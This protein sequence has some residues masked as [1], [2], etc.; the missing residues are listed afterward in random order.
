M[1]ALLEATKWIHH[2]RWTD[3]IENDAWVCVYDFDGRH[4]IDG[5]RWGAA[6][7][8]CNLTGEGLMNESM[9]KP[10]VHSS[11]KNDTRQFS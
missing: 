3:F 6:V 5:Y 2:K 7:S 9:N 4:E 10:M 8:R 1:C 11:H